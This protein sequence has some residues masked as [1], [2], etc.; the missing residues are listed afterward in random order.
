MEWL[1]GS[2]YKHFGLYIHGVQYTKKDG[3]TIDGT[4]M[5]LLFESL[6]DPITSGRDELGMPKVYCSIDV[7]RRENAYSARMGWEGSMFGSLD[8]EDL[9][10]SSASAEGG[11][12]GGENDF[13]IFIYKYI[14][15]TG[16]DVRG[17]ADIE[18]PVIVPH[19]ENA[20]VVPSTVNK[21]W[22]SNKAS[23]KFDSLT[24]GDLPTVHHIVT[25]LEQIPVYEVVSAKVVE[26]TGVPDVSAARRIE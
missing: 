14:P 13:G 20:K 17:K 10:E 2:G 4:Y 23:F 8:L 1:G 5:P 26:G 15:A 12:F 18:Y 7:R 11:T 9:E 6:A 22:K 21:V 3:S 25:K 24:Q 16:N 19:G